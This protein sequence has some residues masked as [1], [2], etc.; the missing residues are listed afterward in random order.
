MKLIYCLLLIFCGSVFTSA[1]KTYTVQGTVQ[2]FH[3]KTM[4]ENAVVRIGNLTAKT[5]KKGIFSFSKVPAGKYTLIA[6]H[7]D[8]NDYTENI[9][10]TQDI[11][12]KIILEHHSNDIETVTIHGNHKNNGSLVVKTLSK[13]D[14]EKNSTENLGSLLSKISGVTALK[15][16]NNISKPVIHGLYGSRISILNNGVRLAE[17]E[18]GVEHAPNVDI[19]NFQHIDVIKEHL[20]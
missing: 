7:P 15:T 16:G 13:S 6:K 5:D 10:V 20:H 9:E 2:D 14:I 18:W 17:Q 1:Q 3:D 19:N 4:L 12:I 11:H 8:C